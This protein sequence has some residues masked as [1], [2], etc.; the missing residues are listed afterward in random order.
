M[1]KMNKFEEHFNKTIQTIN[2]IGLGIAFGV[3]YFLLSFPYLW[4]ADIATR[5]LLILGTYGMFRAGISVGRWFA[6]LEL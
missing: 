1:N 5:A 2:L 4:T 3:T 6:S